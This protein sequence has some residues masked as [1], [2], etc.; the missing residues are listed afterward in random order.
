MQGTDHVAFS[1]RLVMNGVR[2]GRCGCWCWSC[3]KWVGWGIMWLQVLRSCGTRWVG[4]FVFIAAGVLRNWAE[5]EE[6][7]KEGDDEVTIVGVMRNG[8][9]GR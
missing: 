1:S 6:G 9:G 5:E 7:E 4:D 3:K 8:V 2:G